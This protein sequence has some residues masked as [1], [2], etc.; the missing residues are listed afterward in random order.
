MVSYAQTALSRLRTEGVTLD[1]GGPLIFSFPALGQGD[2]LGLGTAAGLVSSFRPMRQIPT[3]HLVVAVHPSKGA[4]TP[5]DGNLG[6][7]ELVG[8]GKLTAYSL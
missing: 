7:F 4:S 6:C 5:A 3:Q 1:F 2:P 8:D